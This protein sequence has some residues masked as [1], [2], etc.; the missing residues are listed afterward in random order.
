[1]ATQDQKYQNDHSAARYGGAII[2]TEGGRQGRRERERE[3]FWADQNA[4]AKRNNYEP[5]YQ[6]DVPP[7]DESSSSTGVSLGD[8]L[9]V[10]VLLLIL[11]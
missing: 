5:P 8:W 3:K 2:D 11:L 6:N 1:M 7:P 9:V 4:T 10:I